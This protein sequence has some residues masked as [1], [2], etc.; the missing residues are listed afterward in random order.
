MIIVEELV[1]D[2]GPKRAVDRVSFSVQK[3]RSSAFLAQRRREVHND[4]DDH[5]LLPADL[6][7]GD[8]WRP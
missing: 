6:R 5:R 7:A 4:A 1:K 2:F 3:G 8:R